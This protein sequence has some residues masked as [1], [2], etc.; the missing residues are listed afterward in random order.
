[1]TIF[2]EKG[3]NNFTELVALSGQ[4]S[5][6]RPM[7]YNKLKLESIHSL[8]SDEIGIWIYIGAH[9]FGISHC[10]SF[11][12]RLYPT[13]D[14]T[15]NAAF[16]RKLEHTCPTNTTVNTTNLD[17]RNPNVFDIKYYI[18][19]QNG[20]ALLT[21]DQDLYNDSRTRQIVN[22]FAL[23]QTSFFKQFALS[24]LKMV[25]LDVLTGAEGEI[26]KN[27]AVRNTNTSSYSIID[28]AMGL[29]SSFSS[30]WP[31]VVWWDD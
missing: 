13:Q 11:V 26:R 6:L 3:F 21:S 20:E 22:S 9:T 10:S 25:Q 17:I 4:F 8:Y 16:A 30:W 28:P 24:M 1:M 2:T 5:K 18:D 27:C 12:N 31:G 23:N 7:I 19:L 15:L 29:S 14:T